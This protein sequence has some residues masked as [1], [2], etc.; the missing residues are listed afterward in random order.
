[1][2]AAV[3]QNVD[4]TATVFD[5]VAPLARVTNGKTIENRLVVTPPYEPDINFSL[6][7]SY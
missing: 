7:R 5:S 6:L 3:I 2:C 1:M 4:E